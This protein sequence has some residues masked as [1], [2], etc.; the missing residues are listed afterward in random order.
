MDQCSDGYFQQDA[1]P[2]CRATVISNWF[3]ED[4]NEFT[5][6]QWPLESSA[7]NPIQRL[8]DVFEREICITDVQLTNLR[9]LHD[10]V[11]SIWPTISK[12]CFQRL[13]ESM[14]QGMKAALKA[15]GDP[16]RY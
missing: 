15:K 10:A 6:L 12:E 8:W 3:L 2:R 13:V 5:V 7:L 11:M 16:T 14:P 1:A 9:R 4:G